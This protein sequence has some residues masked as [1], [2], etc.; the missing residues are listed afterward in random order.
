MIYIYF[1]VKEKSHISAHNIFLDFYFVGISRISLIQSY[2][3][4]KYL[5]RFLL[6]RSFS[7]LS[8]YILRNLSCLS[9]ILGLILSFSIFNARFFIL[10]LS[11]SCL[12]SYTWLSFSLSLMYLSQSFPLPLLL[13]FLP[14][15]FSLMLNFYPSTQLSLS[16]GSLS[17][18]LH[19]YHLNLHWS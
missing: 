14:F 13:L 19:Y 1:L 9:P 18:S 17:P 10:F 4:T 6:W 7:N 8:H 3:D 16:L 15:S 2:F 11:I 5:S 12:S